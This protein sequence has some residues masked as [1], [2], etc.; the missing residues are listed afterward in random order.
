MINEIIKIANKLD[1]I[2]L[3]KEA[4][5]LD[6]IVSNI[7]NEIKKDDTDLESDIIFAVGT[8]ID[9]IK[10]K[11]ASERKRITINYLES[12]LEDLT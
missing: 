8:I 7:E 9:F 11:E 3:T 10:S 6:S 1:S 2:G 4:D 12:I 5:Y